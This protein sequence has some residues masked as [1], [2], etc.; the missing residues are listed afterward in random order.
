V[1][2]IRIYRDNSLETADIFYSENIVDTVG[3]PREFL[4]MTT[5]FRNHHKSPVHIDLNT[6]TICLF[7]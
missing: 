5:H 4:E 1:E 6:G 2:M 3:I 7:C